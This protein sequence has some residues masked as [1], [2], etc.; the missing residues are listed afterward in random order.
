MPSAGSTE[1]NKFVSILD[2]GNKPNILYQASTNTLMI[3]MEQKDLQL[4]G[5]KKVIDFD[6]DGNRIIFKKTNIPLQKWNNFVINYSG[7]TLDIFI[8][9][10][11][12][13]SASGVV[14]YMTFDTLEVGS[15]NGVKGGICNLLYF[16]DPLTTN[17]LY[18]LYNSV[19]ALNPPVMTASNETIVIQE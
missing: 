3:T 19:S 6:E 16:K 8:N 2:Y 11:L 12:V 1:G 5:N 17:N 15:E 9:N 4:K 7:G 13:K 14:P 10:E 18:Y